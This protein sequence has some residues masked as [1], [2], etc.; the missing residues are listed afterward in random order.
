MR[1]LAAALAI[2]CALATGAAQAERADREKEIVVG[3]DR[4]IADDGN[5]TSGD[6]CSSTCRYAPATQACGPPRACP[7]A[8]QNF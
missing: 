6:C 3:A 7:C 8:T 2:S 4:L 1:I 5:R